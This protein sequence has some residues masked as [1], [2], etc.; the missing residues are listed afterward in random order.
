MN[1]AGYRAK[2][3]RPRLAIADCGPACRQ[4]GCRIADC[5]SGCLALLIVATLLAG[6]A[7]ADGASPALAKRDARIDKYDDRLLELLSAQQDKDG[8]ETD[9]ESV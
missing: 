3:L 9:G 2:A 7:L 5:R 8:D 1:R 4:A 6:P